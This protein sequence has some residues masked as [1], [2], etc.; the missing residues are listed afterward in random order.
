[1][2]TRRLGCSP[3]LIGIVF[4]VLMVAAGGFLFTQYSRPLPSIVAQPQVAA[5]RAIGTAPDLPWPGKGG[6]AVWVEGLGL[7]STLTGPL[8]L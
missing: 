6:A 4:L 2:Y 5:E 7:M 1:M 3:A 8:Q